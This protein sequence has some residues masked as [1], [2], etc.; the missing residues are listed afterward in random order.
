MGAAKHK[1]QNATF[2]A[3][4]TLDPDRVVELAKAA[5]ASVKNSIPGQPFV[6]Y[7]GGYPGQLNFSVRNIGGRNVL[8]TFTT[9]ITEAGGGTTVQ[10]KIDGFKTTQPTWM[11]IPVGPK[12]LVGYSHYKRFVAA[13]EREL[14]VADTSAAGQLVERP[15]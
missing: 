5:G 4:T 13:L 3:R 12:S 15:A 7:D 11:F 8:M 1:N 2:T 10:T 9:S 6:Q 14:K